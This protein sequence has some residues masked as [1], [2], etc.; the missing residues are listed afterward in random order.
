MN[1]RGFT[2]IELLVVIAII[3]ILAAILFPVFAR[4]REKA[5]Q[6]TCT[7][8]VK[9]LTLGI[10]MYVTDYDGTFPNGWGAPPSPTLI[11]TPAN[12]RL[13][14][15]PLRYMYWSNSIQ[16]YI[17]NYQMY[18]C[19]S[20]RPWP[21]SAAPN[22]IL[23]GVTYTFNGLLYNYGESGIAAPAKCI[24]LSEMNGDIALNSTA[25]GNPMRASGA[26]P[27][28]PNGGTVGAWYWLPN[29]GGSTDLP[30]VGFH[31]GGDLKGYCDGHAKW[32][33]EPGHWDSSIFAQVGPNGEP[34]S[35]WY[36]GYCLWL[37]RP[38]VQ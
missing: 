19:P 11:T 36:D 29:P 7:S 17:K 32:T 30:H 33:K 5:R 18:E 25:F 13:P 6:T 23:Q 21:Y 8:N 28:Q 1:R 10:M 4:A 14:V 27:Y 38:V 15:N 34:N 3:A 24:M 2:L 31:N 26:H 20:A 9:Q 16:P 12:A 35:A 22:N 37:F